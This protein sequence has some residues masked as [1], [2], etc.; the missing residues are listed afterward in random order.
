MSSKVVTVKGAAKIVK[1]IENDLRGNFL[2][3]QQNMVMIHG[4]SQDLIYLINQYNIQTFDSDECDIRDIIRKVTKVH[5][6]ID[7][8][9]LFHI[10]HLYDRYFLW[11]KHLPRVTP[12]YAVK[13]CPD[14]VVISTLKELGVKFDIASRGE[15]MLLKELGIDGKQ[16]LYANPVKHQTHIS[17]AKSEGVEY[18]TFDSVC[19]LKKVSTV[20]PH[21]KLIL[22]ICV[23]DDDSEIKFSSK[24]GCPAKNYEKIFKLAQVLDLNIVGVS[25]HVG[26]A[27]HNPKAFALA[28]EE[29][30]KVFDLATTYDYKMYILD[31]GGGFPGK[32]EQNDLFVNIA[33]QINLAI[34]QYFNDFEDLQIWAEP[35][36]FFST[37]CATLI[38][39]IIGKN[40]LIEDNK[41]NYTV[42]TG[43]YSSASN[44]I[45]DHAHLHIEVL[46]INSGDSTQ[47]QQENESEQITYAGIMFGHSCDGIDILCSGKFPPLEYEDCCF[48]KEMGAYTL[49]SSSDFNG[50]EPPLR[51]YT[52]SH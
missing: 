19:E 31:V 4:L 6:L 37:S 8:I 27:C 33:S 49:A 12:F 18:F 15:L 29:S 44:V 2:S 25:F 41:I 1:E 34:D 7:G 9:F 23:N 52:Y 26:S 48:I 35:G 13:S 32:E 45:F 30:R 38:F 21:A 46:G 10:D 28:I 42:N 5:S 43:V 50:F 36:R 20:Y 47:E 17:Q 40:E 3:D 14:K 11:S 16:M 39:S 24:F 51:V 22:R